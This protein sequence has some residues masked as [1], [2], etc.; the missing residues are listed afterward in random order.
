MSFFRYKRT[1]FTRFLFSSFCSTQ[2]VLTDNGSP[3]LSST[4]R[5]VITVADVN[6]NGPEFQQK[7][8]KAQIP[9]TAKIDDKLYQVSDSITSFRCILFFPC[10][11][12]LLTYQATTNTIQRYILIEHTRL[13]II[14]PSLLFSL[15]ATV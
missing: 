6:D 4:T 3:K 14:Q 2:V 1:P 8:Y 12:L 7:F 10:G 9:A 13:E 11:P 5:V 15:Y